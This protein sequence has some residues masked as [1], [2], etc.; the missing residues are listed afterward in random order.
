MDRK[1]QTWSHRKRDIVFTVL[2]SHRPTADR[3]FWLHK[4]LFLENESAPHKVGTK[5]EL[6]EEESAALFEKLLKR[7]V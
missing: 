3:R 2:Q 7:V 1:G 5:Q 6:H 4:V